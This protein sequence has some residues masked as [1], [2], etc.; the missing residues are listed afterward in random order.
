LTNVDLP[1]FGRP[2]TAI[3]IGRPAGSA[4]PSPASSTLSSTSSPTST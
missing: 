4:A 2:T 3:W 1:A